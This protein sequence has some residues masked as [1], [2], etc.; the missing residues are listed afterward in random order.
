MCLGSNKQRALREIESLTSGCNAAIALRAYARQF[1]SSA[2]SESLREVYRKCAAYKLRLNRTLNSMSISAAHAASFYKE[3]AKEK[4]I[5][6]IRDA[7]GFLSPLS[8]SGRRSMPFW[9][10]RSR[11]ELIIKN[12][13]AYGAFE[14]VCISWSEFIERWVQG[15]NRPGFVGG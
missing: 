7:Q 13:S 3:V 15:L 1:V 10:S 5:W 4:L 6:S 12:V 2:F 9:S 14:P 8:E 11:A